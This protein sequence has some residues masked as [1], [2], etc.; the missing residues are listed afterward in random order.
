M[1]A[2]KKKRRVQPQEKESSDSGNNTPTHDDHVVPMV[3]L[4]IDFDVKFPEPTDRPSVITLLQQLFF[5]V[6][7]NIGELSDL[8]IQQGITSVIKVSEEFEHEDVEVDDVSY[9]VFSIV[10]LTAKK[11]MECIRQIRSLL[12]E[13]CKEVCAESDYGTFKKILDDMEKHVGL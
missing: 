12:L 1:A 13:K 11:N 2:H 7:V 5:R 8:L 4:N 9:G 6:C 3:V 10:N